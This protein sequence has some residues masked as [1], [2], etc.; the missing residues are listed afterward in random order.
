MFA[1]LSGLFTGNKRQ[2]EEADTVAPASRTNSQQRGASSG[3]SSSDSNQHNNAHH[4]H[5]GSGGYGRRSSGANSSEGS[6]R[7]A[8]TNS[9]A[10]SSTGSFDVQYYP[11]NV[12][13]VVITPLRVAARKRPPAHFFSPRT[14]SPASSASASASA[15]TPPTASGSQMD[16][17]AS[18]SGH[19]HGSS[20]G[21][22]AHATSSRSA[23]SAASSGGGPLAFA[24]YARGSAATC[25]S[26]TGAA[27]GPISSVA[28]ECGAHTNRPSSRLATAAPSPNDHYR[29]SRGGFGGAEALAT[30]PDRLSRAAAAASDCNSNNGSAQRLFGSAQSRHFQSAAVVDF[31]EST[32]AS[33]AK[34]AACPALEASLRSS[35]CKDPALFR[36]ATTTRL[37][38][39]GH[40]SHSPIGTSRRVVL[41]TTAPS[42]AAASPLQQRG[43]GRA[44]AGAA[45]AHAHLLL[46]PSAG[47]PFERPAAQTATVAAAV[48]SSS[49]SSSAVA[50]AALS[51]NFSARVSAK[52]KAAM[53]R[54][55]SAAVGGGPSALIVS[56]TA[57]GGA[58]LAFPT[59]SGA[60]LAAASTAAY[61]SSA[62]LR[63][64]LRAEAAPAAG[65]SNNAKKRGARA[66]AAV[67][68]YATPTSTQSKPSP[69]QRSASSASAN[70]TISSQQKPPKGFA[71]S[72]FYNPVAQSLLAF[73]GITPQTPS[74]AAA[75]LLGG[76]AHG[77][78]T[79]RVMTPPVPQRREKTKRP[80][81]QAEVTVV[82]D[83]DED[84][85]A[86]EEV[87]TMD[88]SSVHAIASTTA[89]LRRLSASASSATSTPTA[90]TP[91]GSS[92]ASSHALARRG[93]LASGR[94]PPL[95]PAASVNAVAIDDGAANAASAPRGRPPLS[96]DAGAAYPRT[97]DAAGPERT[98]AAAAAFATGKSAKSFVKGMAEEEV[99]GAWGALRRLVHKMV[100][101]MAV[102]L[103]PVV[104]GVSRR[105]AA[106]RPAAV[107][108]PFD[109]ADER[110]VASV[111]TKAPNA[112]V[113]DD[114]KTGY[115]IRRQE[116]ETC[117]GTT[118]LGDQVINYYCALVAAQ[119][120]G[121]C[122]LGTF[123]FTKLDSA[124]REGAHR[125]V[126]RQPVFSSRV[127]LV[128]INRHQH[129]TLCAVDNVRGTITYYD[130]LGGA[131]EDVMA[132]VASFLDEAFERKFGTTADKRV[133]ADEAGA[134]SH[135]HLRY[136]D[137][138][139]RS[140]RRS[141]PQQRNAH[142][143]GVFTTQFCLYAA[144]SLKMNFKQEDIPYLRRLIVVE[145]M[146]KRL[147]LRL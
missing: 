120:S 46:S 63:D 99:G 40:T 59:G 102:P 117:H 33:A 70:S 66:E 104:P 111:A 69:Q 114:A 67:G 7:G 29:H 17:S 25:I 13:T 93:G 133:V 15:L 123:F 71:F 14:P 48:T 38:D 96:T 142:D 3:A 41:P 140:P 146:S 64:Y 37:S 43:G 12:S 56:P 144:L 58:A 32:P 82:D 97:A 61:A 74:A 143:C 115:Q 137:F 57:T 20:R 42:S 53:D 87:V 23:S 52:V 27:T 83:G 141:V 76:F 92:A 2:R 36:A 77:G 72:P 10:N 129:W 84:E 68:V 1:R 145:L 22:S 127:V 108:I 122:C 94:Q 91:S 5:S 35:V 11:H 19:G 135:A 89:L 78:T 39:S 138:E 44:G 119:I 62:G 50:A 18:A 55:N 147:M 80:P 105:I 101:D 113:I 34:A 51:A 16:A 4:R 100:A 131:G 136:V 31:A 126:R 88:M 112:Y 65:A 49:Y 60:A 124:D 54:S 26:T 95:I 90:P 75:E 121:V 98:I 107:P 118:W 6:A 110:L 125:W 116:L 9:S 139:R 21:G 85:A 109:D 79:A 103:C 45:D 128:V 73:S 86:E 30:T 47:G 24:P 8:S 28:D 81:R 130:S 134:D 106:G 132:L